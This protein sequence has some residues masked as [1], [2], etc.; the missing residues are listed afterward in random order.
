MISETNELMDYL[1]RIAKKS[2][3]GDIPWS[4]PNPSTFQWVQNSG[5]D[6][7]I[8]TIQKADAPRGVR[9]KGLL[10]I[11]LEPKEE[12]IYLFQVQDRLNKQTAISLSSKERPEILDALAEIYHGAEKGMDVRA[13]SVLKRLLDN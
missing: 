5:D 11:R 2:L 1:F 4:Q 8:V 6:F 3:A 10:D 9:G 7:F 13:T 12:S